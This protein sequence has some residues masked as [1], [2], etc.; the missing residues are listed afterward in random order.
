MELNNYG[1]SLTKIVIPDLVTLSSPNFYGKFA[2]TFGGLSNLKEIVLS[3][4]ITNIDLL[5]HNS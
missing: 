1:S 3:N 2:Y 5:C 4:K